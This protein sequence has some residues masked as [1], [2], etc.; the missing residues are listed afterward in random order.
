[1]SVQ[2]TTW[3][4][5]HSRATGNA[6]LVMLALADHAHPDGSHAYPSVD[7]LARMC[8]LS[9]RTVQRCLQQLV[10]DGE[11]ELSAQARQHRATEYRLP[12]VAIQG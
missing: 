7:E 4:W 1:M 2:A 12:G 8:L 5:K 10:K 6:R 3:V 9:S 11:I